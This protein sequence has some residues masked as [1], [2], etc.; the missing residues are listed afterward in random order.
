M[1]HQLKTVLHQLKT[2]SLYVIISLIIF[3]KGLGFY[4]NRT[5]FF[6]PPNFAWLMNNVYLD[7]LMM[8]MGLILLWYVCSRV[9]NNRLLGIILG[10]IVA[11]FTG[12]TCIEVEHV[13][14]A[15]QMEFVQ[16][17]AS[18]M[19]IIAFIMWTARHYSKR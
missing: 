2:N 14:F 11:L 16:N 8:L 13:I 4:L 9:N 7:F 10:V 19:G 18:N 12:I 15:H 17:A 5:F 3:G 1:L 6:Y